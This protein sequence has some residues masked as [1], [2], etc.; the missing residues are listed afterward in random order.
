MSKNIPQ[1][2]SIPM[3]D[4]NDPRLTAFLLGE[5]E[6]EEAEL[7]KDA[8]QSNPELQAE[9][10]QIQ[11]VIS[12]V[13]LAFQTELQA[14]LGMEETTILR[15]ETPKA[16]DHRHHI[17]WQP[18]VLVATVLLCLAGIG[19]WINT[20]PTVQLGGAKIHLP[21]D[22][23][24]LRVT[25]KSDSNSLAPSDNLPTSD[26]ENVNRNNINSL[27]FRPDLELGSVA[28]DL[29]RDALHEMIQPTI[30]LDSWSEEPG[31]LPE[32]K[33]GDS[34]RSR[35]EY[36]RMQLFRDDPPRDLADDSS[37]AFDEQPEQTEV[38]RKPMRI[39]PDVDPKQAEELIQ[40]L[41]KDPQNKSNNDHRSRSPGAQTDR[42]K[43]TVDPTTGALV[44]SP[45]AEELTRFQDLIRSLKPHDA[46]DAALPDQQPN[47]IEL[48]RT[49]R[50]VNATPNTTRLMVGQDDELKLHG[51]QVQIHV[52]GFRARVVMDTFYY[53]DRNQALEG[54]FKLRLPDDASLFYLAFGDS[55]H[56]FSK[57][58]N[59]EK[60]LLKAMQSQY[61]S[62]E[63]NAIGTA[64][65]GTWQNVKEARMVT[66]EKAAY[67]YNE[68][69]RRR[70]DPA[71]AEWAGAGV[72]QARV[73]PLQPNRM[74]RIVV[75]YD[76]NLQ[77]SANGLGLHFDLPSDSGFTQVEMSVDSSAADSVQVTPKCVPVTRNGRLV[78]FWSKPEGETIELNRM[79]RGPSLLVSPSPSPAT[80]ASEAKPY[81]AAQFS[82]ELPKSEASTSRRAVFLLD[83]SLS[84]NPDKFNVWLKLLE[85]TLTQNR[86]SID[87]FAVLLFSV[88]QYYWREQFSP[89]TAEQVQQLMND[90][91]QIVLEGATDLHAAAR[92]LNQTTWLQDGGARPD[93]FLLSDGAVTWGE[94]SAPMIR[95]EFATANIGGLVA[96][97]T[98]MSGTEVQ[99]LRY[100]ANSFGGA[101]F[102]VAS[103]SEITQASIAHRS[104]PWQIV[105][106]NLPGASDMLTAGRIEWLYP[107]QALIVAGR[108]EPKG[109]LTME[110]QQGE[111]RQT[112]HVHFEPEQTIVSDLSRRVYGQIA[113]TQ[114]ESLGSVATDVSAAYA[115]HYRV[116]G[117]TCSLVMLESEADYQRFDI[118]P[119]DDWL[120]IQTQSA[121][122]LIDRT[123]ATGRD[124]LLDSKARFVKWVTQLESASGLGFKLPPA[125]KLALDQIQV[126]EVAMPLHCQTRTF[127]SVPEEYMATLMKEELGYDQIETEAERRAKLHRDD[128]VK[129]WSS[130]VERHSGDAEVLRDVA[131]S[132]LELDRADHAYGLLQRVARLR[133][134]E[135]AIYSAIAD[136]LQ[137]ARHADLSLVYYEIALNARFE[138]AGD[139]FR[140]IVAIDFERL[141]QSIVA[142]EL[143]SALQD[144]AAARLES[145]RRDFP[146]RPEL[147]VTMFWNTDRTD[148]DL[149]VAEPT[150]EVCNYQ[151]RQTR[152]GGQITSDITTGYGPE[153]YWLPKAAAGNYRVEAHYFRNDANR[154][155]L[156]C[157]VLVAVVQRDDSGKRTRSVHVVRLNAKDDKRAITTV[158][159]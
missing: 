64:R 65:D 24:K 91:Q 20:P 110:V 104:R 93:V 13:Q 150:E 132:L 22:T 153:M 12:Q 121:S 103:E 94:A 6:A 55:V 5:L 112:L 71:L 83:T 33:Q 81:F 29:E 14:T 125:L 89:N 73:F 127:T 18:W 26:P 126:P 8:L 72:F 47:D 74:H 69:V 139:D 98:G 154:T 60:E 78:Y 97:Q 107:G 145:L 25:P 99:T 63:P 146:D 68:T 75:G 31:E 23:S 51:T 111:T 46:I 137:Q 58:P 117:D 9:L 157:R 159:R 80:P 10:D 76:V 129:V 133:P 52:D 151:R 120:L 36:E 86:D 77:P 141:L 108:G 155:S 131:W 115:R 105:S 70:V 2:P 43:V 109:A 87:S 114:L 149:H 101:V 40:E 88:D 130:L 95:A 92:K 148:V 140:R 38:P 156:A 84:S 54:T 152:I 41:F 27:E 118:R 123:I 19:Y 62:L 96:Y 4:K 119:E 138:R 100:L 61:V 44:A 53:N 106:L 102:G 82:P 1:P 147:V 116:A 136:A 134:F 3:F 30:E 122:S 28:H 67:A 42:L 56:D 32:S 85:Q 21:V 7:I 35:G 16:I 59:N 15:S 143:P 135:G 158:H 57:D 49:W 11:K 142:G 45:T 66:R 34:S 113:V 39:L 124:L 144:Y 79:H 90:C 48:P 128:A 17:Q 50:R 37:Q